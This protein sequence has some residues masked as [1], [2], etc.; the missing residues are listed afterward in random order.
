MNK[1]T[2]QEMRFCQL[3]AIGELT[4]AQIAKE[5]GMGDTTLYEWK[6]RPEIIAQIKEICESSKHLFLNKIYANAERIADKLIE[7]ALNGKGTA[8]QFRALELTAKH[9]AGDPSKT[10]IKNVNNIHEMLMD[11]ANNGGAEVANKVDGPEVVCPD[12]PVDK[13]EKPEDNSPDVQQGAK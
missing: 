11:Y 8:N 9:L 2:E 3:I 6:R 7:M 13:V 5:L 1:L 10:E 12:V 4:N